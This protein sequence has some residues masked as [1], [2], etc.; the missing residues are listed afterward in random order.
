MVAD[1]N[2]RNC[3][4]FFRVQTNPDLADGRNGVQYGCFLD[5]LHLLC[6][7][8]H[9]ILFM[10]PEVTSEDDSPAKKLTVVGLLGGVASGK[11]VVAQQFRELGAAIIDGDRLGHEVLTAPDVVRQ[12]CCRWGKSILDQDGQ[13]RRDEVARRVFGADSDSAAELQFL[14]KTTHPHIC[15]RIADEIERLRREGDC[16]IAVLDAAVLLKAGW[17]R[18]CDQLIYVDAS[19]ETRRQ[20]ALQRG[21]SAKEFEMR[22]ASQISPQEKRQRSD[23]VIDNE[24]FLDQTYEQALEVWKSLSR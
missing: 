13:I 8:R 20:R 9:K 10:C 4:L 12:L 7:F 11:S 6:S 24:G 1:I 23:I 22:E 18:F 14:E 21:W 17:D 2:L 5:L 15:Q 16:A 19:E 3:A